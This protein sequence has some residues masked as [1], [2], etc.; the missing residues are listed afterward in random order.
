VSGLENVN[1]Q[2]R[3]PCIIYDSP[4]LIIIDLNCGGAANTMIA[5]YVSQGYDIKAATDTTVYLTK[6]TP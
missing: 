6:V 2:P 1:A 5:N 3:N 4:L